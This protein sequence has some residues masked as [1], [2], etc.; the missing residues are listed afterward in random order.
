MHEN[1]DVQILLTSLP[2][3]ESDIV[4][5]GGAENMSQ[6]PYVIRD[7]RFGIPFGTVPPVRQSHYNQLSVKFQTFG[8]R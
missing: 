2:S 3:G 7:A 4:T 5:A 1:S 6:Y 8:L